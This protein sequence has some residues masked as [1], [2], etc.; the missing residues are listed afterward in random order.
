MKI[1][2]VRTRKGYLLR[3]CCSTDVRHHHLHFVKNSKA[4]YGV[5]KIYGRKKVGFRSPLT[6]DCWQ[7]ITVGTLTASRSSHGVRLGVCL[8]PPLVGPKLEARTKLKEPVS[9]QSSSGDLGPIGAGVV[10]WIHRLW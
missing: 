1:S 6:G 10:A 7:G 4:G 9:H 2:Q 8:W 3:V 5:G